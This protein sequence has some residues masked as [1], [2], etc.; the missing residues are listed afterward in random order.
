MAKNNCGWVKLHRKL[1]DNE[2]WLAEP[3]TRGQAWVD[4]L[5]LA[6][7]KTGFI[8][9]RGIMVKV[10]RGQV[11]Y[12]EEALSK[13]WRWSRNKLRRFF[14]ELAELAMISRK[15][16]EI[17][18]PKK[19]QKNELETAQ[20]KTSITALIYIE[21][22]D[23]YQGN[24]TEESTEEKPENGTRT[25]RYKNKRKNPSFSE[26]EISEMEKRYP[27]SGIINQAFQAIAGTRKSRKIADS[28]KL[29]ILKAWA[30]YPVESVLSGIQTY[31]SKGYAED[32][33]N[34]KYLAGIIRNSNPEPPKT[35]TG[36]VMKH[37]GSALLDSYY[38]EQGYTL[39]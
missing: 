4:L 16:A 5:L 2:L 15:N 6:N 22:Y 27:D 24:G 39:I 14:S 12:S 33:K 19:V 26:T 25:R 31:L 10:E 34:E 38:Q 37:T 1:M 7:H 30:R 21:N 17:A 11:G 9:R 8:R 36:P 28:V 35:P 32:G 13:R 3:F 20:K 18:V 29:G 23:R